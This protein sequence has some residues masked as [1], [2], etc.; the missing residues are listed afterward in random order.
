MDATVS[1]MRLAS[2]EQL[3]T[4]LSSV[5]DA[6]CPGS[7]DSPSVATL[8]TLLWAIRVIEAERTRKLEAPELDAATEVRQACVELDEMF[9]TRELRGVGLRTVQAKGWDGRRQ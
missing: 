5:A 2:D 4:G 6:N 7:T 3:S 1:A 9:R 8:M